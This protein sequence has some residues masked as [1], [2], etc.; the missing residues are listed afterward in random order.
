[1]KHLPQVGQG[2]GR[3]PECTR[4]CSIIRLATA[5]S[6]S[7]VGQRKGAS[8]PGACAGGAERQRLVEGQA[9]LGAREGLVVAVHV[10]LVF[11]QV[12][13]AHEGLPQSGHG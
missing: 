1:M 5:G 2:K 4:R 10:A 11:A 8:R 6:R 12:R 3:S 9:A 7:Q 13:G